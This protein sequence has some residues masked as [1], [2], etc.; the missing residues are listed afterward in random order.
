MTDLLQHATEFVFTPTGTDRSDPDTRH[1]RVN[2]SWRG[3]ETWAVIWMGECWNGS[4]WEYEPLNSSRED[5]FLARTRYPL[6]EACALAK[7]LADTVGPNGLTWA[8]WQERK[9]AAQGLHRNKT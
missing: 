8:L 6:Q 1:F 5:D 3:G 2:V 9:A 7:G 4:D